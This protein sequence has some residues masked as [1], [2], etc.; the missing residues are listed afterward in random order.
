MFFTFFTRLEHF[1][2][3]V[4]SNPA[5]WKDIHSSANPHIQKFPEPYKDVNDL[6]RLIILKCLRPDKILSTIQVRV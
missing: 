5:E 2:E 3:S 1:R 4:E 6:T